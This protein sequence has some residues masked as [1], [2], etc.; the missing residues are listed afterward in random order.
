MAGLYG[1]PIYALWVQQA[2]ENSTAAR[3]PFAVRFSDKHYGKF[4]E[5]YNNHELMRNPGYS[6]ADREKL[7]LCRF[8]PENRFFRRL[9]FC[10]GAE[11]LLSLAVFLIFNGLLLTHTFCSNL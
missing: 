1:S 9:F 7:R 6:G 5:H 4:I 3:Q 11:S 10:F 2:N 8:L